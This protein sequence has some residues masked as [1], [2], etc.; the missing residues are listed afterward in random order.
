MATSQNG[1]PALAPDSP[2]LHMWTIPARTGAVRIRLRD[3][4][5][6][7][8]LALMLLWLA[9][10]IEPLAG[11][12]LDDWGYAY[13]PVR[14][15]T[16]TLSNHSSGTAADANATRH[17]LGVRGTFRFRVRGKL[18]EV[19]IRARLLMFAGTVRWGGEY[20]GRPDEMHFEINAPLPACEKA[21]RRLMRTKRGRRLLKANPGQRLVIRS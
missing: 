8:L 20:H 1:W 10:K 13:R 12:V 18:A 16:T 14:G 2:R 21:A 3:G 6:G 17:P 4:S 15:S 9:E 19:R 11:G 7:F 5:A